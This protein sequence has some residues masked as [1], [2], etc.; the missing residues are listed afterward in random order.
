MDD[1]IAFEQYGQ[2]EGQ[3]IIV[4]ANGTFVAGATQSYQTEAHEYPWRVVAVYKSDNFLAPL[5]CRTEEQAREW[6]TWMAKLYLTTTTD[7][8][9]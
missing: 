8:E 4:Q 6:L 7:E 2:D 9:N 5:G 3:I 1:T